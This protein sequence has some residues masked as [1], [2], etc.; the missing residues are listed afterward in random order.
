MTGTHSDSAQTAGEWCRRRLAEIRGEQGLSTTDLAHRCAEA[1]AANITTN[2]L[3]NIQTGRRSISL[4]LVLALSAVLNVPPM[5][6][7]LPTSSSTPI[8]ITSSIKASTSRVA[9]WVSGDQ[10]LP[11]GREPHKPRT[12][13]RPAPVA[14]RD[15]GDLASRLR[16]LSSTGKDSDPD[17]HRDTIHQFFNDLAADDSPRTQRILAD[18]RERLGIKAESPDDSSS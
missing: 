13:L 4:D 16:W 7:M 15:A 5:V 10:P 17:A 9:A 11:T 2:V 6:L 12:P 3:W 18:L 1:G 8:S 14:H